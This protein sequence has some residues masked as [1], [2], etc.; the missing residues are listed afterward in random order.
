MVQVALEGR[1]LL[2]LETPGEG[3]AAADPA[4]DQPQVLEQWQ[5][6]TSFDLKVVCFPWKVDCEKPEI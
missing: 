1:G 5:I 2:Q 4:P 6:C 3:G